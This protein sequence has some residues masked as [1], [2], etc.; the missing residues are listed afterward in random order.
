M[1]KSRPGDVIKF[2]LG[3]FPENVTEV[4]ADI[5]YSFEGGDK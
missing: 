1:F 3:D 2:R 4:I 5:M